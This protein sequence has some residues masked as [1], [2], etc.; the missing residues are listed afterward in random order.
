MNGMSVTEWSVDQE[1]NQK[2]VQISKGENVNPVISVDDSE[3]RFV[4]HFLDPATLEDPSKVCVVGRPWNKS[5]ITRKTLNKCNVASAIIFT[6]QFFVDVRCTCIMSDNV[7]AVGLFWRNDLGSASVVPSEQTSS[8][9]II[10]YVSLGR[11]S[12]Y[13]H[14]YGLCV[15]W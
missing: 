2:G 10:L 9:Y 5:V 4:L 8:S 6:W 15:W 11:F 1:K 12:I 13:P 3:G 14:I 7:L